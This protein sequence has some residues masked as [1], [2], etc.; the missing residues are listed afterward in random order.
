M[1]KKIYGKRQRLNVKKKK[2]CSEKLIYD[3]CFFTLSLTTFFFVFFKEDKWE[4][5]RL[6][7]CTNGVRVICYVCNVPQNALKTR[8]IKF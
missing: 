7:F 1:P 5:F 3:E 2:R 4:H 8:K 6:L